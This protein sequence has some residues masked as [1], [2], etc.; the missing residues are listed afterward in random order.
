[1]LHKEEGLAAQLLAVWSI[2]IQTISSFRV[3]LS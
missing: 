2:D 1:M 3:C